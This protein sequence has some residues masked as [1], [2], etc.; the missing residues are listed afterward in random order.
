M[1]APLFMAPSANSCPLTVAT[2]GVAAGLPAVEMPV[3]P[4]ALD[5]TAD[6][7]TSIAEVGVAVARACDAPPGGTTTG[8]HAIRSTTT[9]T[10]PIGLTEN[11]ARCFLGI[12]SSPSMT[13]GSGA[14][15]RLRLDPWAAGDLLE[16]HRRILACATI[17]VGCNAHGPVQLIGAVFE[18]NVDLQF[19]GSLVAAPELGLQHQTRRGWAVR[20]DRELR[21]RLGWIRAGRELR[22]NAGDVNGTRIVLSHRS[23]VPV[24]L[25]VSRR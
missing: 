23:A 1:T 14:K 22:L 2:T 25:K 6:G 11:R 12:F 13:P 21:F 20:R 19:R 8:P 5:A 4:P 9:A 24:A 3:I 7:G 18:T 16:V 17:V 15:F 10:A